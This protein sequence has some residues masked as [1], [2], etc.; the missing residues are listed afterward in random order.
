MLTGASFSEAGYSQHKDA[1]SLG[2]FQLS[3]NSIF[4]TLLHCNCIASSPEAA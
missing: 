4:E 1:T 2:A 3:A